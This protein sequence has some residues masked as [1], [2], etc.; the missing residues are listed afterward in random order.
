M[1]RWVL[2]AIVGVALLKTDGSYIWLFILVFTVAATL[3]FNF[4][5]TVWKHSYL[6]NFK[7]P[8]VLIGCFPF[9][10]M[11]AGSNVPLNN[12]PLLSYK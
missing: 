8:F 5:V 4:I 6:A 12:N 9:D 7:I 3:I 1:Y 11:S 10:Y 2:Y